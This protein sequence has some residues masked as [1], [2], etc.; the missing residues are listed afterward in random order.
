VFIDS[1][2]LCYW[3]ERRGGRAPGQAKLAETPS[4]EPGDSSGNDTPRDTPKGE[5]KADNVKWRNQET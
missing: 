5:S 2:T 3:Q 4:G 1:D